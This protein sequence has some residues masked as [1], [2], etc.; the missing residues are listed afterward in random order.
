[1]SIE[2]D[3]IDLFSQ[4][5]SGH[6]SKYV[7]DYRPEI[8]EQILQQKSYYPFHKEAELVKQHANLMF[9]YVGSIDCIMELGPGSSLAVTN[10]TIPLLSQFVKYDSNLTYMA[11]DYSQSYVDQ[12]CD[13]VGA[14]FPS[15]KTQG[16]VIDLSDGISSEI[17]NT[18]LNKFVVSFGQPIFANNDINSAMSMLKNINRFMTKSDFLLMGLDQTRDVR[19]LKESY[20]TELGFELLMNAFLTLKNLD[21]VKNF[22]AHFFRPHYFW[23]ESLQRVE[24]SLIAT[25]NQ[26]FE[27]NDTPF[28]ITEGQKFTLMY[29]CKPEFKIILDV[30][31][32]CGFKVINDIFEDFP[33]SSYSFMI[34]KKNFNE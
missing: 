5:R 23:N 27:I 6:I 9:N 24:L 33:N 30:L 17:L 15:I 12:A 1:M 22:M 8:Y 3:F 13:I 20:D 29:S 16:K 25:Q 31:D 4:K 18:P 34:I 26:S 2:Q 32:Q 7:Y 10:K 11:V 21:S 19:I 14:C 28:S